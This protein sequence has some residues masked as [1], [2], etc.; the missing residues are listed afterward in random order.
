MGS[1]AAA[2]PVWVRIAEWDDLPDR[3]P[4]GATVEGVDIVVVRRDET[5]SVLY[6]RCLH[7]GARLSDGTVVGDD[8]VCSLHG[9]DYRIDTGVSAYDNAEALEKFASKLDGGAVWVDRNAV[10]RWLL[11]HPQPYDPDVYQGL[12]RDPH[13]VPEEPFV[14]YIHELAAHGLSKTGHHGPVA[15][16]GVPR[17]ELPTWDHIQVV[18]AQLARAPR[19][20]EEPVG[21]EVCIGPNASRPLWLDIPIFVSDMSFGA[22]SEEAKVALA[23][24]A[25]LAGTGICSGEGGMLPEEQA[26][27]SRYFYELASARFGWSFDHVKKVQAFHFKGG[28]GAKTGTGGH[29]PGAKVQGKIAAVRGLAPG[30][31]AISPARFADFTAVDDFKRFAA[32]VRDESGGIPIGFK[33]SAQHVEADLDAALEIGVDYVILDGRGGG[34]GAAPLLFRNN[35]LGADDPG[36]RARPAPSR[37]ARPAR[38]HARDH[39]RF[40]PRARLRQGP[41]ARRR[42]SRDLEQRAPGDRLPRHARVPLQRMSRRD[43]HAAGAP[44]RA[45][46]RRRGGPAPRPILARDGRADAGAHARVRSHA[47]RP[48][49]ARRPRHVRSRDAPPRRRAVRRG[50]PVTGA[51]EWHRVAAVGELADGRVTTVQAGRTSIA[52]TRFGGRFG[53]LHNRC[54]HQ[55]GPLGEGSIEKG[56]LRCPWHG[57]DYDP[58]TGTPPPGFTDRP[59]SFAVE[60]RGDDVWVGVPPEPPRPRTVGDVMV[61]TMMAWGVTHVFGMVGHSNLGVAD[62]MRRAE[63]R[64]ELTFVGIRHEG[65]AAFAASAYGKLTGELAACFAIAGPGSTNLLTGLYDAKVDRSP[66]LAISGQ[67]ATKVKGRGAFQD[68]DLTNAF[69]DVAVWSQTV[70]AASDHAELMTLACKHALDR[71]GVAHVVLPD[72]VQAAPVAAGAPAGG[73]TGRRADLHVAPPAAD[74]ERARALLDAAARPVIVVG[75]GA[76]FDM[77]AVLAL[78]ERIHAPVATTFKAKG[79]VADDHPLGCGVLGRSGTPIASWFMNESDLLVVFGA[80]FSDHTGIAPYKPIVQVDV[81]PDALGRFHPV[82]APVLG[83]VGVTARLFAAGTPATPPPQRVDPRADV[84]E[85]WSI[86]RAEKARR[87]ADDHGRGIAS[88]ALFA[89]LTRQVDPDAVIAVDVGNN[90]Y[91]FGRYF[92]CSGRQAVLM[93]GYLGS[94]GFGVPAAMG[95]WAAVGGGRQVVAVCGDGGFGQYLGELTTLVRHA[96]DV[97]VVVL[98]NGQLAKISKEQRAAQWDVWQTSL[99][100]PDFAA[101]ADLCGALGIR[102]DTPDDLD[103]ALRKALDHAGPALVAVRCDPDLA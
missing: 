3:T 36:A 95:A 20:D 64:G 41:R 103:S 37:P 77:P 25:E 5:H 68:L 16:M 40:A 87:A 34:T 93:S 45:T 90:T 79:L 86:W 78:A 9:W 15:A 22:L 89:A 70:G 102:V 12:Y 17:G 31:P 44:A 29:L 1:A 58:I 57:Y 100:N 55:G 54:P 82:T 14:Q 65:A 85:R 23:R 99:H 97:T 6:G 39:G 80:S 52:L 24:G 92:E 67:V 59:A 98:D 62:A 28:Q 74:L 19:L 83:H 73:P 56:W 66:V 49:V 60:V 75:H 91:S 38:R 7:R 48:A 71:R 21:T 2:E 94:I 4:V 30:T 51:L 72:E 33:L 88:A 101:Y 43:R 84:A 11:M 32:R 13:M 27:N 46:P 18:T 53:A 50:E 61:E 8:L 81:D 47:R 96:M 76:R 35:I 26:E 42:R 63:Q 69:R 10:V